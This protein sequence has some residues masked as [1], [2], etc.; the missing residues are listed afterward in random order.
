MCAP[1]SA[2]ILHASERYLASLTI[3]FPT[4]VTAKTGIPYSSASLT[5]F[6]RLTIVCFSFF[7]PTKID[8]A[9]AL[10]LSLT[11]SLILVIISSSERSSPIT[12]GPPDT[13][14][15]IGV[16]ELASTDVRNTPRVTIKE[17]Q[18]GSNGAIVFLGT[19]SFS[20]GPRKYPWS[21]ANISA[22]LS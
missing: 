4:A 5:S 22:R 17:S 15:T 1:C 12:L 10:T 9:T 11:A 13:R 16:E 18:C 21:T 7:E 14:K 8:I 3:S 20:V 6:P 2:A 19:S